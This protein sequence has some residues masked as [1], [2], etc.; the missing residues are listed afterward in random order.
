MRPGF[1]EIGGADGTTVRLGIF[2]GFDKSFENL[3]DSLRPRVLLALCHAKEGEG[4][5]EKELNY[6]TS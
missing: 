4:H 5:N 3:T 1:A 6:A 2:D